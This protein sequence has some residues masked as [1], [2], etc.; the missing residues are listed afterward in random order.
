MC[1]DLVSEPVS[2]QLYFRSVVVVVVLLLLLLLLPG[3]VEVRY[4]KLRV[5]LLSVK[6]DT[7][8]PVLVTI[9][10]YGSGWRKDVANH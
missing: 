6:L 1:F 3:T 8:V 7:L 9:T 2:S 4:F 10:I 5:M